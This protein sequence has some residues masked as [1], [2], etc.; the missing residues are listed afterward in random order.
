MPL[1]SRFARMLMA[2]IFVNSGINTFKSPGLV[3]GRVEQFT[4]KLAE[5]VPALPKDTHTQVRIN[6]AAQVAG[7]V[8]LTLGRFQRLG[9][10]IL[11]GSLIPTT[12]A[13]HAFWNEDD[14]TTRAAQRT[15][16][17]KNLA[18]IGALLLVLVGPG[19]QA[20]APKGGETRILVTAEAPAPEPAMAGALTSGDE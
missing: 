10:L 16:F 14:P 8:L 17:E 11:I 4:T 13:G 1:L 18:I 7:G 5:T 6:A 19:R 12:W 9:A 3:A 15:Q 20:K 2:P